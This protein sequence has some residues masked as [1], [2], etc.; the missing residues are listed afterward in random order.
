[1]NEILTGIEVGVVRFKFSR[2]SG[3]RVSLLACAAF[4]AMA[5]VGW[6]LSVEKAV[7][8]LAICALGLVAIVGVAALS[9]LVLRLV[10]SKQ[11]DQD[12]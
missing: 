12:F 2:R 3:L 1:M 10:K 5:I 11:S 4:I 9:G 8:Y 6:D 7:A